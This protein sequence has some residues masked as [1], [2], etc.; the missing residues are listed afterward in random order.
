MLTSIHIQNYKS[1]LDETISLKY[2]E[3]KAP[4]EYQNMSLSP[5]W[6]DSCKNK[7][8]P[9]LMLVGANASGKSNLLKAVDCFI[10]VLR[11]GIRGHF[12]PNKLNRKFNTTLFEV[13]FDVGGE[14]FSYLVEYNDKTIIKELLLRK[15]EILISVFNGKLKHCIFTQKGYDITDMAQVLAV[16]CMDGNNQIRA[17]L[18]KLS[19]KYPGLNEKLTLIYKALCRKIDYLNG[20]DLP[21]TLGLDM[22]AETGKRKELQAKI[23]K[24]IKQFDIDIESFSVS[25]S[26]VNLDSSADLK[27]EIKKYK[28][29]VGR[30]QKTA[31][32]VRNEMSF[33]RAQV[34]DTEGNSVDF[35]FNEELSQGTK[36]LFGLLGVLL[37][38][39]ERG[40]VLFIDELDETL[41]PF[42]V[43]KIIE[44]FKD[45]DYNITKKAQLICTVQNPLVME[46]LRKSEI[47][48]VQK[49]LQKGTCL[50]PLAEFERVRNTTDFVKQYLEGRFSA[51][52]SPYL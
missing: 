19:G 49:S 40:D 28:P 24:L 42:I 39:L 27:K 4:G 29:T 33:I 13:F 3:G 44:M 15:K 38:V 52:P 23:T 34:K 50:L 43:Q 25:T 5:F 7:L 6:E 46:N 37:M 14:F 17:F 12:F 1:I 18:P 41:H 35:D 10:R 36:R 9:V 45:P 47:A 31:D 11:D 2:R 26:T 51:V 16:E 22:A 8:A 48:F 32:G 21:P 20:N 30:I